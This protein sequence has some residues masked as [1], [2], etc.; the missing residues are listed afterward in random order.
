MDDL[1]TASYISSGC[2]KSPQILDWGENNLICFGVCNAVAVYDPL[3]CR[4]ISTLSE[5]TDK[6]NAVKWI[7]GK[8]GAKNE[9]VSASTDSKVIVWHLNLEKKLSYE[10]KCTLSGHKGSVHSVDGRSNETKTV[11]A[12][13]GSDNTIRI[14]QRSNEDNFVCLKVI[15]LGRS[16]AFCLEILEIQ[17]IESFL[18]AF[19]TDVPELVFYSVGDSPEATNALVKVHGHEDWIRSISMKYLKNGDIFVASS[20]QDM[21]VRILRLSQN[22]T[23]NNSDEFYVKKDEFLLENHKYYLS[24]ETVL[25]GHEGWVYSVDWCSEAASDSDCRLLTASFDR[26]VVIWKPCSVSGVWIEESRMGEMGGDNSLG[27]YGGKFA[28]NGLSI[29]VHSYQGSFHIWQKQKDKWVADFTIGGHSDAV[30]DLS[31]EESGNY[32]LSVSSD[33]TTRLHAPGLKTDSSSKYLWCE[34]SRPQIHG[35]SLSSI[36][37]LKNLSFA[38]CSEEKVVRVFEVPDTVLRLLNSFCCSELKKSDQLSTLPSAGS[39]TALGLSNKAVYESENCNNANILSSNES[40]KI[41]IFNED[42][43]MQHTLWPE[44]MK[45]Y[46]HGNDV[47]TAAASND[48]KILATAAKATNA[49]QA[50]ILLW[51][52]E[53]WKIIGSLEG[54]QLTITQMEFSPSDLY[55]LSVSRDRKWCLFKKDEND[56]FVLY[57]IPEKNIHSRIIWSCSWSHD[58]L[59]FVTGSRDCK[60]IIWENGK[61]VGTMVSDKGSVTAVAFGPVIVEKENYVVAVGHEC[62]DISIYLWCLSGWTFYKSIPKFICHHLSVQKLLFRP[63]KKTSEHNKNSVLQLASCSI[64]YSV[65]IFDLSINKSNQLK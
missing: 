19:G 41:N 47:F 59:Y 27:Y 28:P 56:K 29:I 51:D 25:F 42:F 11:I 7:R 65:R 33:K 15:D 44:A 21:T 9:L 57:L 54:H 14:W 39:I 62:G 32:L 46:G 55:L 26:T 3:E 35:H 43:L 34:L 6:V 63:V 12:S 30:M 8:F 38:S 40:T 10:V 49:D 64:D 2:N 16:I 20:G 37:S 50:K 60:V 5:H 4:I 13:A 1:I 48:G 58:E 24:L 22:N 18:L 17:N 53:T 61:P 31:W 52:T 45:L 36:A 23:D